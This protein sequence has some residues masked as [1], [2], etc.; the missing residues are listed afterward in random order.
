MCSEKTPID[1]LMASFPPGSITGVPKIRAMEVIHELESVARGVY[2]GTIFGLGLDETLWAN[3][4]IRTIQL[5]ENKGVMHVGGGV[6]ADSDPAAEYD[7][8]WAKA[9][10][11]LRAFQPES[12]L[13]KASSG[14]LHYGYQD[15]SE[16]PLA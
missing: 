13:A 12:L 5:F 11:V 8:T 2:C 16:R 4:A 9:Q 7:E 6:V 15:L 1:L 3:V 14:P 10:G